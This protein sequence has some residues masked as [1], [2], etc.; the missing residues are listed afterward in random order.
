M[1]TPDLRAPDDLLPQ[2]LSRA[3]DL[4]QDQSRPSDLTQ[5]Q[6]RP[7][8]L[9]MSCPNNL[10]Q[11]RGQGSGSFCSGN[12]VVTCQTVGACFQVIGSPQV[13]RLR[14]A[15]RLGAGR[16]RAAGR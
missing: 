3:I 6:S 14:R 10:C 7:P 5:D 16:G 8:D 2:D 9:T 13:H 11:D 15:L 4:T 1:A 12:S